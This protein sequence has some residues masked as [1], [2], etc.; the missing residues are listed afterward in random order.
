MINT[1]DKSQFR[2]QLDRIAFIE[3]CLAQVLDRDGKRL[4]VLTE[5]GERYLSV[6]DPDDPD[7]Y[8]HF[9]LWKIAREL[10]EL[11]R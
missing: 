3:E 5:G 11:I 9:L 1:M 4:C 8:Y 2:S 7:A 10:E 6:T